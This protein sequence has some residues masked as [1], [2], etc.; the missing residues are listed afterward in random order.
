MGR[1]PGGSADMVVSVDYLGNID[2]GA[3]EISE[4]ASVDINLPGNVAF[5]AEQQQIYSTVDA[6]QYRVQANSTIRI[7]GAEIR[8]APGDTVSAIAAKIND[9]HAPVRARL[10]S[11][12]QCPGAEHDASAP[13]LGRG[14]S[15]AAPCCRTWGSS[16]RAATVRR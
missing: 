4:G 16:R 9:A 2:R 7:D 8:L 11:V 1:V 5:W 12:T 13:D 15:A 14:H 10:D 3:A 6:S